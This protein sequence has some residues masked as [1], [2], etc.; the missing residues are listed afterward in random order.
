MLFANWSACAMNAP[1]KNVFR[2]PVQCSLCAVNK[3]LYLL[4]GEF[5]LRINGSCHSTYRKFTSCPVNGS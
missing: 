3:S 1:I 4:P 5:R 2:P